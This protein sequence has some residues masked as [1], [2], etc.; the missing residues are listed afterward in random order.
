[1]QGVGNY[2]K[3]GE[4]MS[5][6]DGWAALNLEMPARVPHT[7]YSAEGHW[8]LLQAVTGIAVAV[9]SPPELK[10]KARDAF[11]GPQGWN[12]DLFWSTLIGGGEF[13]AWHTSMGHAVYA[14]GGVDWNT[15]IHSPFKGP[16][17]VLRFDPEEALGLRDQAELIRRFEEHYRANCQNNPGGVNMTGVYV[18][19]ISGF[20]E[21]FGWDLLLLAAGTD[22]KG[23][24][25]LAGRYGRWIQHYFDA[26]GEADIPVV[27]VHDDNV[28]T[29]GPFIHPDWYRAY[30][31]PNY[32]RH[33]APLIASGK[34]ILF[35]ADGT[36]TEF[37]D[38]LVACGVSGFVMEPTTDMEYVARKYGKT[39]SFIGN[40]DTRILLSGPRPAIRAEVERC[41]AIGKDCPGFFLAVGNHIPPNTP[42]EHC[43]YYDEVYRQLS[44]R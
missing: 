43:L 39:H 25:E 18:T 3:K 42:V 32:Q 12:L 11:V 2:K 23:F 29:Q 10:R 13:G 5:W 8:E 6:D 44:R 19:C 17:E 4:E 28:W 1:M 37:I 21:L 27:M 9:D 41:M 14:A 16:E 30:V 34:K 40:A 33:L 24:G 22:P 38:D 35:T 26:L 7:E 15:D 36:Y 31:F 20:I